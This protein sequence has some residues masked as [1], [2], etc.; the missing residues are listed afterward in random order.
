MTNRFVRIAKKVIKDTV[1]RFSAADPIVYS[2]AIAF[3]TLFS[4]PPILFIVVKVGGS[5]IGA[6]RI[7]AEVYLQ[8]R[9][10]VGEES[11]RQIQSML[12]AGFEWN[13]DPIFRIL[14]VLILLFA[15][16]VVFA[17]IKKALNSIWNVKPKPRKGLLKFAIDRLLSLLMILAMGILI[18]ASL[19][20]DSLIA[21]F[22]D[23]F[24]NELLGLTPYLTRLFNLLGS[25]LILTLIFGVLFK[26]LPDIRSPWRPIWVGALITALL[27]TLGKFIIGQ[28]ISSTDISTTYGAAGSLAAILLWVFYSSITILLGNIFTKIYFLHR[29]YQVRPSENAVAIEVRELEKAEEGEKPP[30]TAHEGEA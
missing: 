13:E 15:A 26:V 7:S 23:N 11:A 3:F 20:L 24:S 18:V 1:Q 12:E 14:S 25:F 16:T 29:G 30:A 2:A 22:A 9:E 10:K 4:L 19:L 17:F 6:K 28:I 5:L 21:L 27:F 8:V